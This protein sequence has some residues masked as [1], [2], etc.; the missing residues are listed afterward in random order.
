MCIV[1]VVCTFGLFLEFLF[2][3][4]EQIINMRH[5]VYNYIQYIK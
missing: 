1:F 2:Q 4:E 3:F 5:S